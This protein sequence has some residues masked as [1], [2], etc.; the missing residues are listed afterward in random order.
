MGGRRRTACLYRDALG[1]GVSREA[2]RLMPDLPPRGWALVLPAGA[3]WMLF[4]VGFIVRWASVPKSSCRAAPRSAG[5]LSPPPDPLRR[6][7]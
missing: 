4:N 3:A 2:L 6:R 5:R 7:S 1:V